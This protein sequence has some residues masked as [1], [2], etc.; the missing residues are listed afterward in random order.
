MSNKN[1]TPLFI[2]FKR[3][4]GVLIPN[5]ILRNPELT[6]AAKLC[7]GVLCKYSGEN[8]ECYPKQ[9]DIARD[10]GFTERY[11]TG[12]IKELSDKGFIL[13]TKPTGQE[14]IQ[15]FHN[16]YYFILHPSLDDQ[17]VEGDLRRTPLNP[18][19]PNQTPGEL[20]SG[21]EQQFGSGE[22]LLFRSYKVD[23]LSKVE[24]VEDTKELR[25]FESSTSGDQQTDPRLNGEG[26]LITPSLI[27]RK[28]STSIEFEKAPRQRY[29][30]VALDVIN[31]WN[32][33]PGLSHHRSPQSINGQLTAPTK[34]FEA[35]VS[36]IGKVL[37]GNFFN[38]VGLSN[39]A[40]VYTKDELITS[41]DRFKLMATHPSYLPVNKSNIRKIGLNVFF[42]N[43]YSNGVP[44]YFVKCL[45]E[46]PKHIT[47]NIPLEKETT[48]HLT[49]LLKEVYIDKILLG[50]T[51]KFNR[52]DENG[53]VRGS[54]KLKETMNHLQKRM[55]L[56][57]S[58]NQW[59]NKVV[60]CL[61][62]KWGRNEIKVGH[63]ASD[64]T[65]SDTLIRYLKG[66]G[67]ID[68]TVYL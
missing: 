24:K 27:R 57:Y 25:S 45:E 21:P 37:N 6:A 28:K 3:Y 66:L 12:L 47:S 23:T 55:N 43:P 61:V 59:C 68:K 56:R 63:L 41:I 32:S 33:S 49:A 19:L 2:P 18:N 38:S 44:S 9:E 67:S 4:V 14:R 62:E 11:V 20:I 16:R 29:N 53:F 65:Y 51:P 26:L 48:P 52:L 39:Y 7:Y 36:T 13:I 31:Y 58:P 35:A 8:G 34:T 30:G 60:D 17:L 42:Y 50:V 22:E 10:M 15:H 64:F 1:N 54:N 46:E 5:P 40:R